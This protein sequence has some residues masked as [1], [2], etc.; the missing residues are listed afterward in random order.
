MRGGGSFALRQWLACPT[1]C[2]ASRHTRRSMSFC[3]HGPTRPDGCL[4]DVTL[5]DEA[6]AKPGTVTWAAGAFDGIFGH[7]SSGGENDSEAQRL[8]ELIGA[9]GRSLAVGG[10][11]RPSGDRS[12]SASRCSVSPVSVMR[13]GCS[14]P[15][16]RTTSSRSTRWWRSATA[17]RTAVSPKSGRSQRWSTAGVGSIASSDCAIPRIRRSGDGSCALDSET[18]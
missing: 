11:A 10:D 17:P 4:C 14:A 3:R 5:P 6:P 8:A 18:R 7:H 13:P 12:S 9:P 2:R 15:S 1:T 16:V